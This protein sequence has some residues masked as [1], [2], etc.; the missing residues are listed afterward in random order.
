MKALQYYALVAW[1]L[2]L[3]LTL[4]GCG[5]GSH[6]A[7]SAVTFTTGQA[8]SVVIGQTDFNSGSSNQ[9]VSVGA[10]T[11]S[12]SFAQAFVNSG[13]LYLPDENNNRTLVYN[14]IPTTNGASADFAIGQSTLTAN[15]SGTSATAV[16]APEQLVISSGKLIQADYQNS[17]VIIYNSVPTSGP[18]TISVVVGQTD[19]NSSDSS[20]SAT[21]LGDPESVVT[22]NGKLIVADSGNNRIL[23]YNSI[24]TANGATP[25]VVL[26]QDNLGSC[27]DNRGGSAAANNTLYYPAGMWS[28]GTRLAVS[29]QSNNRVLIWNSIPTTNGTAADVV[30]GQS[31]FNSTNCNGPHD[32]ASAS[33]LCN[34]YD[35]IYFN[36]KQMFVGDSDNGRVLIWNSFPTTNGQAAD[37]VLGEPDFATTSG[38]TTVTTLSNP[39]GVFLYGKQLIVSDTQNSR[40]LIYDGQ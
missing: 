14:S 15:S 25:D 37:V 21:G 11:L 12:T 40:Y 9:S 17:R 26:G 27:D 16:A 10:N 39:T 35:G 33:T 24:P 23:I 7:V 38:G 13:V 36:S 32:T 18:G 2:L 8:A 1:A 28:D 5:S 22:A 31:D 19:L 4:T 3:S 6:D 29:D 20:C 34:P 30:L